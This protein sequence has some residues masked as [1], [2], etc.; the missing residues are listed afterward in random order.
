M[1]EEFGGE[2]N[3]FHTGHTRKDSMIEEPLENGLEQFVLLKIWQLTKNG[4]R[5]QRAG[6]G[7]SGKG[8]KLKRSD[9]FDSR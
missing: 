8:E 7:V 3:H 1:L 6:M 2:R 9:R 4:K 5:E